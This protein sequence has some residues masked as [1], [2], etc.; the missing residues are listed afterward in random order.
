MR[1][2][3]VDAFARKAAPV[4]RQPGQDTAH[5]RAE[6][7]ARADLRIQ[8]RLL[9]QA[10]AHEM[11]APV[12]VV[13]QPECEHADEPRQQTVDAVCIVGVQDELRVGSGT[14]PRAA[15]LQRPRFILPAVD[16]AVVADPYPTVRAGHRLVGHRP[17]VDDRQPRMNECGRCRLRLVDGS[18]AGSQGNDVLRIRTAHAQCIEH[19]RPHVRPHRAPEM[20]RDAAHQRR[21]PATRA[22][23][24]SIASAMVSIPK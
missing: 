13:D 24:A 5:R 3:R 1:K 22:N 16:F 12:A 19:S 4:R 15:R 2:K 10:I 7:E 18:A 11:H 17:R 6:G 9:A 21:P 8:H 14:K 20:T 23:T